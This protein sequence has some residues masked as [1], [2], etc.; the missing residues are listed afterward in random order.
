MKA[1][2]PGGRIELAANPTWWNAF[3]RQFDNIVLCMMTDDADRVDALISTDTDHVDWIDALRPRDWPRVAQSA[4]AN[5]VRNTDLTV[6][7]LGSNIPHDRNADDSGP[8]PFKELAIRK[9][10]YQAIDVISISSGTMD[11]FA[12]PAESVVAR[13][14]FSQVQQIQRWKYDVPA[15]KTLLAS[16]QYPDGFSVTL[17]L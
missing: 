4:S 6:V 16:S 10:V 15:A 7:F 5:A 13:N 1:F 11:G 2:A 9:A 12:N 8:N 14:V 17:D 3:H